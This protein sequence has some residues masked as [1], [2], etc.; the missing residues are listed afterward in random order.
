MEE[1]IKIESERFNYNSGE[2]QFGQSQCDFCEFNNEKMPERC[3]YYPD[4]KEKDI[5]DTK[6]KCPYIKIK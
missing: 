2:I 4:G 3:S 5:V 1:D 6:K